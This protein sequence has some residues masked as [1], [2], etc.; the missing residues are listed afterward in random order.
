MTIN[1]RTTTRRVTSNCKK[2]KTQTTK[3]KITTTK[4]VISKAL[5]PR[6]RKKK[7]TINMKTMTKKVVNSCKRCKTQTTKIKITT[8]RKVTSNYNQEGGEGRL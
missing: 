8:T 3:I 4:R 5:Q 2:C 7:T 6:G 1:M